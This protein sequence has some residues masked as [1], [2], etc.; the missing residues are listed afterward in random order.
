MSNHVILIADHA[1]VRTITVNRPDK[2]NALNQATMQALDQAFQDAAAADDVRAVILTG[3]GPKAFVAGADIAEMSDLSAIQG[4]EFSLLGQ[5]LMR[6]IER[7]PKPV[8][9]MINGFT[10]GGGLELAMA[11]HLR[12]AAATAR[13]GQ[14]EINLG[15][16]PGFGGTQRLLRLT[17]RAAALELCLLGLPIDAARAL[18]LGLVNRVVEA[19]ALHEETLALAQ[20]LATAAPLALR[21]ILDAVVFGGECAIEEGLQLE[22]A[23][24]ALL[25]ATD[26][27]RE[28]TRA[29][30]DK[31]P[32]QFRNR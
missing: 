9:A 28:G 23:Q 14:P 30:L 5:R 32:A 21:G 26:D 24:F 2:L 7:M 6:R 27:M 12:I 16:I 8:I 25:F 17:G 3:A 15:L 4:R 10:L 13:L 29:F 1:S 18:Q 11:C 20:R 31:R 19:D 22:T